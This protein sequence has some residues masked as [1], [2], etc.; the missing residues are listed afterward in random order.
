MKLPQAQRRSANISILLLGE[1]NDDHARKLTAAWR[2]WGAAVTRRSLR[3]CG[4]DTTLPF[5]LNLGGSARLPDGV[6][7]RGIPSGSFE[8]VTLRLGVLHALRELG[9]PVWNDARAIEACIDKAMTSHLLA[10]SGIPTPPT[11]TAQDEAGARAIAGREL[12]AG[13]LLV[14][15]PLFGAQGRGLRL[16]RSVDDIPPPEEVAGVYYLQRF[17]DS[18]P[19]ARDFRVFVSAGRAVAAMTRVGRD[20]QW[21]TN[22]K[23]GGT[24][25]TLLPAEEMT[26]LAVCA[27]SITGAHYAGV[28]LIR[29]RDGQTLVLEVNSMPAWNGLQSVTPHIDITSVL[30]ADFLDAVNVAKANGSARRAEH[31]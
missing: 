19:V 6:F 18:G 27:A 5:G 15:K 14:L 1:R 24:P 28:D 23:Q 16:V 7:V 31:G 3:D 20:G 10:K 8:Q 22:V 11:F 30:A 4:I 26:R 25:Q 21:I 2:A 29:D 12:R 17:I 9:V 13:H